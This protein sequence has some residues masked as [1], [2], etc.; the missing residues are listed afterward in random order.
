MGMWLGGPV[1]LPAAFHTQHPVVSARRPYQRLGDYR[2]QDSVMD[3]FF[4]N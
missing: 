2:I 1:G 3:T 4:R